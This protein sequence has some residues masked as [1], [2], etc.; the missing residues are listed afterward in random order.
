MIRLA[1]LVAQFVETIREANDV[2]IY[3]EFSL[4][5]ELGFFLRQT[6][7]D[8]LVQFE[9][10]VG[11]FFPTKSVFTKREIDISILSK[12]T[13]TLQYAIELKF[14]R[15]GQYPEQMYSFCKDIAFA[16]EL[17]KAGF[18]SAALMIFADHP[19]YYQGNTAGI[20]GHF[21]GEQAL[22]G[23][24]QKPTGSKDSNVNIEGSYVVK[25]EPIVGDLKYALV[26]V[27]DFK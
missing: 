26:E 12:K 2:E 24:V 19:L 6:M 18:K 20:Y 16:E 21:R 7:T 11:Y 3:N 8:S 9:R 23:V 5:H 13:K 22:H 17:K 15:N 1:E 4:Q 27:G 10:N 25:W 14:P